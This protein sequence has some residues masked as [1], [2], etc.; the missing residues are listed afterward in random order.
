VAACLTA[1][2]VISAPASAA[3]AVV[4]SDDFEGSQLS[5]AWSFV[6][7]RGDGSVTVADGAVAI[8]VPG[9]VSHDAWTGGNFAPR[10]MQSVGAG[11][12]AVE[13][14][15]TGV[16]T[17][18]FQM[19]GFIAEEAPGR[20][21]RFDVYH[22]GK[23]LRAFG[24]SVTGDVATKRF[25]VAVS[26]A[27][28]LQR[29]TR[30]GSSWSYQYSSD[31]TTWSTAGTFSTPTAVVSLG[32]F[33]GNSG[34]P[35]PAFQALLD[36]FRD[37]SASAP[38]PPADTKAPVIS[39][40]AAQTTASTARI[41]WQTDEAATSVV[42]WGQTDTS[43][44]VA[45]P[46]LVTTHSL[47]VGGLACGTSY[48]YEVESSDASSNTARSPVGTL[49]TAPCGTS[50]AV[51]S[52]DFSTTFLGA[53]WRFR[54]PAGDARLTM[55]GTDA[56]I[57][58]RLGTKHELTSA[59]DSLPRL[60]QTV[61]DGDFDVAAGYDSSVQ[62]RFQT[63]SLLA[64]DVNGAYMKLEAYHDGTA[65]RVQLTSWVG[66]VNRT[67]GRV[68]LPDG[69]PVVLRLVRRGTAWEARWSKDGSTWTLV[70]TAAVPLGAT[71]VAVGVGNTGSPVS[72]SPAT[73]GWV[74]YVV[75]MATT[76]L[77]NDGGRARVSSPAPAVELWGG[78]DQVHGAR[79]TTQQWIGLGGRVSDP[80]GV[81]ELRYSLDGGAWRRLN[82]G[83]DGLRLSRA[84]DFSVEL[85]RLLLAAGPHTVLLRA[86]DL[87]GEISI[88]SVKVT[89]RKDAVWPTTF[90]LDWGSAL[91]VQSTA[92]VV[93][94]RWKVVDG[95]ARPVEPGFDRLL[96][97]GER[98][99]T[100]D[101]RVAM[102]VQVG[103]F[104]DSAPH[105]GV[106]VA[107]GWQGHT[108]TQ[109]PR[110]GHPFSAL[111][112]YYRER[113]GLPYRLL[114]MGTGDKVVTRDLSG[115][116]MQP[117]RSYEIVLTQTSNGDGTASYTCQAQ[118]VDG[119]PSGSASVSAVLVSR[120][121]S[122]LLVAHQADLGI[123]R[124]VVSPR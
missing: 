91:D 113:T 53:H 12:L 15:F 72:S 13:A 94:G 71:E 103:S 124:V 99:W 48:L 35:A 93:D 18:R 20:Y 25:D 19:Q 78:L 31:G 97:V 43:E 114:L 16:P 14:A 89:I 102:P 39:G 29:L 52:D 6:N 57:G 95:L 58:L 9:P 101:Y 117:G 123:G 10:L 116:T 121:G 61:A 7:P 104:D 54:D 45:I 56:L 28:R 110:L 68:N 81:A 24:A 100:H 70:A 32:V 50:A 55:S 26:G 23:R 92:E 8:S 73:V 87:L 5:G 30:Q 21:L 84:G 40:V 109:Q 59:G 1:T 85:D 47:D 37:I 17:A 96:A 64:Q 69:G 112:F 120:P 38:P 88:T 118:A 122:A 11:D 90:G 65:P 22:D 66:G 44:V 2:L 74:D 27:A 75:N 76:G 107:V 106:G 33:A 4:I 86:M 3:A 51:V 108:G 62:L 105:S 60:V 77:P 34:S 83:P 80:D 79:G 49:T 46:A 119:G 63:Q 98:T 36:S 111:C 42:R 82:V 115:F 67:H 41:A